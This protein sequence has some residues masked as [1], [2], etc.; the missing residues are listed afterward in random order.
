[1]SVMQKVVLAVVDTTAQ[2]ET[3]VNRLQ[4]MGFAP[5]EISVLFPDRRGAH[6]FAFEQHTKAPEGAIFGAALG[7]ALGAMIGLAAGIG[8]LAI[9]GL[10]ALVSAGPVLAA[11]AVAAVL[12]VVF[13]AVGA[14]AGATVPEIEARHYTGK[15]HKGTILVGVHVADRDE[16]RR[17]REVFRSVAASDVVSTGEAALPVDARA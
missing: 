7:F 3:T 9:P 11:L 4:A 13:A 14:I 1:M 15:L 8:A 10:G 12:S 2:A 16:V 17:A 5:E 6:D